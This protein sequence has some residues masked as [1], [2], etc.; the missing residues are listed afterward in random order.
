MLKELVQI[1]PR[2]EMVLQG[3][4]NDSGVS[5]NGLGIVE[6]LE[7]FITLGKTMV[8]RTLVRV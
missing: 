7:K 3:K 1:P 2:S 5:C 4:V 8:A 6:P